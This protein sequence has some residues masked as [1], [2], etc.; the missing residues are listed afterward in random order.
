[1]MG[2]MVRG[3]QVDGGARVAREDF[4]AIRDLAYEG[5]GA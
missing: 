5:R 3:A 4:S 1:M 2:R